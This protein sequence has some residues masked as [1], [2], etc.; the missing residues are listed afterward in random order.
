MITR[1]DGTQIE[2]FA[3]LSEIVDA[4]DRRFPDGKDIF[5]RVSRLC[6][7]S[8]ELAAAVNHRENMGIKHQKHGDA[9]DEQLLK[10]IQD[11]M[12]ACVG[13]AK[14]YGLETKLEQSISEFYTRYEARGEISY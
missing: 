5:Q 1:N 14:H 7:E 13:I 3:G 6:E 4:L 11:V 2:T 8:G 12:R 9:T 10:E